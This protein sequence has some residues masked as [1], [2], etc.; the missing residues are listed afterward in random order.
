MPQR[1]SAE[2]VAVAWLKT[3]DGIPT[4]KVA[5]NL[6][7]DHNT[8]TETGFLQ[9]FTVGGTPLIDVPMRSP[10]VQVSCWATAP[11]PAK[12]PWGKAHTL[13]ENVVAGCYTDEGPWTVQP[14]GFKTVR[15]FAAWPLME[16]RRVPSDEAGF[17]RVDVDLALR[18]AP[19]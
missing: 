13:A 6:P 15:L 9:V 19:L 5:T 4:D 16:P 17:A 3:L 2:Q 1:P 11:P 14:S 10:S 18:W 12:A 8:W 7:A